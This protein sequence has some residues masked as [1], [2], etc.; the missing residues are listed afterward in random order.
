M[1]TLY[2][3][4]P[5]LRLV[6]KGNTP[7]IIV[8]FYSKNS[9]L[10]SGVVLTTIFPLIDK[11]TV[12]TTSPCILFLL[13]T[14]LSKLYIASGLK[15]LAYTFCACR[16]VYLLER[17]NLLGPFGLLGCSLVLEL[18]FLALIPVLLP[19]FLD[20]RVHSWGAELDLLGLVS[21]ILATL[22]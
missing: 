10:N 21:G 15:E 19:L 22:V 3:D 9:E 20:T 18:G 17:A 1:A 5:F 13:N 4:S 12:E 11:E 14:E 8:L 6:K 16:R 7:F 2:Q